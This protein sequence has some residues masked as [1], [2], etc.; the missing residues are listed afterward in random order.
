MT[1]SAENG[2]TYFHAKSNI[3]RQEVITVIGRSLPRGY[4][5]KEQTFSDSKDIAQWAKPYVNYL[6]SL[7]IVNGYSDGTLLPKNN[8]TRAEIAK[9]IYSLY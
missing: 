9:I 3:A 1:G 5:S 7:G 2:K 8:I 4:A 6:V